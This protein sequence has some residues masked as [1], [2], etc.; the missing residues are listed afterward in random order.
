MQTVAT[1]PSNSHRFRN[2]RNNSLHNSGYLTLDNALFW[3]KWLV[4]LQV[5]Y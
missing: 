4:L 2:S 5:P 1:L 3:A